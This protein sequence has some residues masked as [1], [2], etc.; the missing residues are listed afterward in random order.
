MRQTFI[1]LMVTVA[2]AATMAAQGPA[3]TKVM[4]LDGE[5]G[6]RITSGN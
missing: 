6:G 3:R 5:S 1:G 4:L 2:V